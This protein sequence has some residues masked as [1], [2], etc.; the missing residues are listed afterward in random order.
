MLNL[1]KILLTAGSASAL[2]IGGSLAF[3]QDSPS[4]TTSS[5]QKVNT[6][7]GSAGKT[8]DRT[9]ND[10]SPQRTPNASSSGNTGTDAAQTHEGTS[11]RTPNKDHE[12]S[13]D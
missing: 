10:P 13:M 7:P 6:E 8:S 2:L 9:P 1:H 11:D 3:A 12:K 5:D 4:S